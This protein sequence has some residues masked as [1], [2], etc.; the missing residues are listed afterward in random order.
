MKQGIML[1]VRKHSE[2]QQQLFQG[3]LLFVF[4]RRVK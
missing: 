2:V 4:Q 1:I 3:L